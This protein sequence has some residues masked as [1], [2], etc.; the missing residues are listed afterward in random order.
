MKKIKYILLITGVVLG[1]VSCKKAIDVSPTSTITSTSFFKTQ[2]DVT[3]A[4]RGMY[5]QLRGP[6]TSDLFFMGEGRSEVLTSAVAGTTGLDRYYNNTLNVSNPGPNWMGLY[7]TINTANLLIKYIPTITFTSAA[8][9]NNSLAQAYSMRAFVY[10]ALARTWGG[11]PIKLEATESYDPVAV[12]VARSSVEDVFKLI[13][14]DIEMALSLYPTN[15]PD[16]NRDMWSKP[17]TS[18][19]KGDVFLWTGKVMNGG[20]ADFT[21]ALNALNDIPA[22]DYL[23]LPNYSDIFSYT[24]KGN[25]EE[26][27]AVRFQQGDFAPNT[28]HNYFAN[29]YVTSLSN[30]T[31]ATVA[32]VGAVGVGNTGNNIMQVS[33]LVRNQFTTDDQRRLGTFYEIFDNAAIPKYVTS[34][35]TKGAGTVIGGVRY[36]YTD[37]ILYRYADVLLM[38]AEAK[39]ALSQDPSTEINQVRQRAYGANYAAHVFVSGSKQ[40]N[41]DAILKERL[42][43]LCTEGKRWWDLVRFG[44]AFNLVPSLAGKSAQTYLLLFPIGQTLRGLEPLVTENP[45]WQ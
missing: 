43:E 20:A 40:A 24:N 18:A 45:G 3:G 19:L 11:V 25:K 2:D 41:D 33:A 44:Q 37:V 1:S 23:L 8:V 38:K 12:Q 27:M 16:T 39:N 35:T 17:A 9:K 36:F 21:T 34:I 22:T 13:K 26:L 15:S 31:P 42:L 6:A 4:L 30:A 28:G 10:F 14:S 29:M 5:V 32:F 7:A